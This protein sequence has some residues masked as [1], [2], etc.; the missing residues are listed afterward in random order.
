MKAMLAKG[1]K[2]EKA[3]RDA[4]ELRNAEL[5]YKQ[6]DKNEHVYSVKQ[7]KEDLD[8]KFVVKMNAVN[9]K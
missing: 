3:Q 4:A 9:K 2:R 1:F 6:D 7:R 5:A 8:R